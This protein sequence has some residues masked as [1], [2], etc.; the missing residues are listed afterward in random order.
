MRV[1]TL[2]ANLVR[3]AKSILFALSSLALVVG[4]AGNAETSDPVPDLS[5]TPSN[6]EIRLVGMPETVESVD[7]CTRVTDERFLDPSNKSRLF[8]CPRNVIV[9][10]VDN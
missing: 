7:G 6:T 4:C 1:A 9:P 2:L 5:C 8:C 3:M 10:G